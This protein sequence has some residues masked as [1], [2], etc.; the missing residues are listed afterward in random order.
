MNRYSSLGVEAIIA[1]LAKRGRKPGL[2]TL[3][4]GSVLNPV[5]TFAYN[6][7]FRFG[8]LDGPEG[9]LQH[10]YHSAYISWKYAKAWEM[11]RHKTSNGRK[12]FAE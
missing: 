1:R 7:I 9:L 2:P 10:L 12:K 5:A 3:L 8:F 11:S 4:L 6:Y